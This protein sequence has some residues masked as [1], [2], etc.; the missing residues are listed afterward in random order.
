M[1][2]FFEPVFYAFKT[3]KNAGERFGDWVNRV[4]FDVIKTAQKEYK[5][6]PVAAV[7][8]AAEPAALEPGR[9]GFRAPPRPPVACPA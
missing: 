8:A 5:G 3:G 9:R 2:T 6:L 1:E 7:A 4:G